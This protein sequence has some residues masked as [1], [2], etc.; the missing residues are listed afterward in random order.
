M[1]NP[2]DE[3]MFTQQTIIE[4]AIMAIIAL[5]CLLMFEWDAA[6]KRMQQEFR[7]Q[8][9]QLVQQVR[10]RPMDSPCLPDGT[11]FKAKYPRER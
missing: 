8:V 7:A 3:P 10:A 4:A 1:R 11:C 9:R 5:G 2:S 6:K